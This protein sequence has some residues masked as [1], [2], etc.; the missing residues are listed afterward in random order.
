M[1]ALDLPRAAPQA[2]AAVEDFDASFVNNTTLVLDRFFVHRLRMVSGKGCNPLNE[3]ELICESLMDNDGVL[4]GN[5]VIKLVPDQTVTKRVPGDRIRLGQEDFA[6][7]SSAFFDEIARRFLEVSPALGTF[8]ADSRLAGWSMT[9]TAAPRL[10]RGYAAGRQVPG[11]Q[12][13]TVSTAAGTVTGHF[14]P[15]IRV[16]PT[17]Y[18]VHDPPAGRVNSRYA[19]SSWTET[20]AVV[21]DVEG[22]R[23]APAQ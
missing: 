4:R 6:R 20:W 3:V 1:A 12:P 15:A 17:E 5:K 19:P 14:A 11:A 23:A 9:A 13:Q 16:M 22:T 18:T 2:A 10:S 7:L 21:D 8:D